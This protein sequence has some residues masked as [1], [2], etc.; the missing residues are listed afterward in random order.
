MNITDAL[1]YFSKIDVLG[2]KDYTPYINTEC[3]RETCV[4]AGLP[5]AERVFPLPDDGVTFDKV[6]RPLDVNLEI[7]GRRIIGGKPVRITDF[8]YMVGLFYDVKDRY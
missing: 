8:P 7:S 2:S 3:L 1:K 4:Q 6:T 5:H